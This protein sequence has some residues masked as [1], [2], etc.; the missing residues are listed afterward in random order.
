MFIRNPLIP[1]ESI[2]E[3]K[4]HILAY[5]EKQNTVFLSFNTSLTI[6]SET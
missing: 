4:S 1:L 2:M 6:V 5:E 3:N